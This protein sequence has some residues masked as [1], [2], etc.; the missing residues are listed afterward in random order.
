[1]KW[2]RIGLIVITGVVAAALIFAFVNAMRTAHPVG[3]KLIEVPD[4]GGAP[5]RVGVWYPTDAT[6]RPT[7]V[8]GL[9]LMS[10]AP[11]GP[12]AGSGLPLIV[13]SHGNAGGPASHADLALALADNGFVVAAPMHT[14]DNYLDQSSVG[15]PKWLLDRSRH[16]HLTIEHL[17]SVWPG[18]TGIDAERVGVFGFSAGGFTALTAVGGEP[19]LRLIAA[20]CAA[21][22]EF[23]C[24][25]LSEGKAPLMR[26]ES[27]PA[28]TAFVRD[29]RIRAAVIAAPGF[30]FTFVP[31]GLRNVTARVQ[32][33][34]GER[35]VNVPTVTNAASVQR[36]LGDRAEFHA[37]PGAQHFSF[38]APCRLLGP[39]LL[40]ADADG[41]DRRAFHASLNDQIVTFYK[42][43][44]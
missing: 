19:D 26:P 31:D 6:P 15:T 33:W 12:V 3:F 39:P 14:G 2:I 43:S 10:V 25:L 23:V 22:P 17:L 5:T 35:D 8:L 28:P 11:D 40:C 13:I 30:G 41:F 32:L 21:E 18:R 16:V 38:L 42:K 34:S 29:A 24:R 1:M 9:N 4:P 7:T 27:A 44:L 37:V 36:A 20:H